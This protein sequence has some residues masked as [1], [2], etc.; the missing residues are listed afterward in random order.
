[1][2][3]HYLP[4]QYFATILLFIAPA[5]I[6]L[7]PASVWWWC[8]GLFIAAIFTIYGYNVGLHY[9]FAHR[10]FHFS[11]PVEL[12]LIY[13]STIAAVASPIS[14]AVHHSAHH[15]YTETEHDPH[16]PSVL[17]WRALFIANYR[18]EKLDPFAV[19]RLLRD[20]AHRFVDTDFGFWSVTLSWPL[21][22]W[23]SLGMTG[24]VYLWILPLWYGLAV[25]VAFVLCHSGEY[26]EQSRS[27]AINSRALSIL[28]LG[29][30]NHLEHHRN[31]RICGRGTRFFASLLG[32]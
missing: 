28:S 31:M 15:R 22:M 30:G 21:V 19:R 27:R 4:R 13:L 23:L 26:D 24:L 3:A 9:G 8:S 10:L 5:I 11:R 20:P 12:V 25:A 6:A 14:W 7:H 18:T 17:G 16:S 32:A 1:M 29:D 2:R